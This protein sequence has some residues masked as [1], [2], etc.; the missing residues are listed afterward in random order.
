MSEENVTALKQEL[1]QKFS[2][3]VEVPVDSM[4]FKVMEKHGQS[5]KNP[6]ELLFGKKFITETVSG[7]QFRISPEAFFQVNTKAAEVSGFMC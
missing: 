7:L 5:E 4:F 2:N 1:V 6:P 3:S